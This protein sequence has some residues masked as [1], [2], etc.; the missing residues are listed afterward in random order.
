VEPG[1]YWE[2][3]MEM[4]MSGHSMPPQTSRMCLPRKQDWKR[5]PQAEDAQEDCE[6]RDLK[7]SGQK[8]SW[9]MVCANG[10]TGEGEMTWT[11]DAYAGTTTMQSQMGAMSMHVKGRKVGG[12]CDANESRRDAA[13]VQRQGEE[14]QARADEQMRAACD[15]AVRD[16]DVATIATLP[17]CKDRAAALCARL[18]TRE[19]FAAVQDAG[20]HTRREAEKL[21]RK[22]LASVAAKLCPAAAKDHAKGGGKA[23]EALLFVAASCP[24]EARPIAQRECAGRSY[25][26]MEGALRDFCVTYARAQLDAGEP[27]APVTPAARR[28]GAPPE[29]EPAPSKVEEGK[30][31][32]KGLFGR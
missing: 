23:G 25:T 10:M 14:L 27:G 3:T 22:D 30:K 9:K 21:C 11:G 4:R 26:D 1:V 28:R 18:E 8:M 17:Q 12:D 13:R 29:P 24:A 31:I 2:Q 5:P 20:E 16:M 32:L 7:R 15:Q 19:G 6:L